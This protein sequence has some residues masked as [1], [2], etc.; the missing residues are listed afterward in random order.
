MTT[1]N[2]SIPDT[3]RDFVESRV[4]EGTFATSSEY[5]RDLVRR[6]QERTQMRALILDGA[7]SELEGPM[8][9]QFFA[10]LRARA[11]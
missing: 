8:D 6:D 11:R 4:G 7:A 1:M 3:M 2:I 5:F 9:D 10:E